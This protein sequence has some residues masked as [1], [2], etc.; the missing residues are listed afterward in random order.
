MLDTVSVHPPSANSKTVPTQELKQKRNSEKLPKQ[1]TDKK[2]SFHTKDQ[3][4]RKASDKLAVEQES[5]PQISII[6]ENSEQIFVS[7][8]EISNLP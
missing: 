3:M 6:R 2:L 8:D 5:L 1:E 4:K 7:D